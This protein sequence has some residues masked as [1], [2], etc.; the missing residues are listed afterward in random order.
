[1]ALNESE[2]PQKKAKLSLS[3]KRHQRFVETSKEEVESMSKA[4][5]PKNTSANTRWAVK[6][7]HEWFEDYNSRHE[8]DPCPD[9]VLTPSCSAPL[10][11]KWLKV[12]II[13]TRARNGE[14]YLPRSLYSLL[15]GLLRHM[16][17][18]NLS[19]SKFF[20]EERSRCSVPNGILI[21]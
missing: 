4:I 12:F 5:M 1:M 16:H 17:A 14:N 2:P 15:T 8:D 3:L 7:F 20:G 13:E 9:V 19:Y 21:S 11:N 10:L 18:E 6:N